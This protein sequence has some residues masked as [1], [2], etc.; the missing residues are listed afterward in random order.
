M[1]TIEFRKV[2]IMH[3]KCAVGKKSFVCVVY[4][5]FMNELPVGTLGKPIWDGMQ[6]PIRSCIYIILTFGS[7][8]DRFTHIS[9]MW[10]WW[11]TFHFWKLHTL[12]VY[13]WLRKD[14]L[15]Q[16]RKKS[17]TRGKNE[18]GKDNKIQ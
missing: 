7:F 12:V 4:R 13:G 11:A 14:S 3:S 5:K 1:S 9:S 18:H 15:K 8:I 16:A 17:K 2:V 10:V 6:Q